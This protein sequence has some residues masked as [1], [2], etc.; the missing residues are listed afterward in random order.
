MGGINRYERLERMQLD[1]DGC[2]WM[3]MDADRCRLMQTD[4][5]RCR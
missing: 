2:R 3:Q 4:A 1:A 5:D